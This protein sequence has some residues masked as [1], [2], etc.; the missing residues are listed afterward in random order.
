MWFLLDPPRPYTFNISAAV[1]PSDDAVD[2]GVGLLA[3]LVRGQLV[4]ETVA[5]GSPRFPYLCTNPV[6][7]EEAS[8]CAAAMQDGSRDFRLD[9]P[10]K[11]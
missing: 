3:L 1:R 4:A 11:Q 2:F 8:P 10:W 7:R 6:Q 5:R 9:V